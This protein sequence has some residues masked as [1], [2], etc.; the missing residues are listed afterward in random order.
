M[1]ISV[2]QARECINKIREQLVLVQIYL[3][4]SSV[5]GNRFMVNL[6]R[7]LSG[8]F[9]NEYL[10]NTEIAT[11][12]LEIAT[13][14]QALETGEMSFDEFPSSVREARDLLKGE[15]KELR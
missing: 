13:Q 9:S 11:I 12:S 14:L 5:D 4:R 3:E 8:S 7:I 2:E 10:G 1:P 6:E 15:L